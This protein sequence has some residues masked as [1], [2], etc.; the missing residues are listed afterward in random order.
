MRTVKSG[1]L[2]FVMTANFQ[3]CLDKVN[4]FLLI[5]WRP[6]VLI[7]I[8]SQRGNA[9]STQVYGENS[10]PGNPSKEKKITNEK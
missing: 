10:L 6:T 3:S 7:I 9:I 8:F 1:I 5:F 2:L 4:M